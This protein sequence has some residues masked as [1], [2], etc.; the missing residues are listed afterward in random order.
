VIGWALLAV[1]LSAIGPPVDAE[2]AKRRPIG[3]IRTGQSTVSIPA[4][5]GAIGTA[6]A[7]CPTGTKAVSGGFSTSPVPNELS[8]IS[9]KRS[10]RR[11]W[12]AS[13]QQTTNNAALAELTTFVYCDRRLRRAPVASAPLSIPSGLPQTATASCPLGRRAISG[14]FEI[15]TDITFTGAGTVLA[16]R[17]SQP[18]EWS[19]TL[20]NING[21]STELTAYA[22]CTRRPGRL[23]ER[24]GAATLPDS[25]SPI[26]TATAITASC[27][28]R[29]GARSGGFSIAATG[30]GNNYSVFESRRAGR[31]WRFSVRNFGQPP[32]PL[33]A[34][35]YCS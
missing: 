6:T 20:Q 18:G 34:L 4:V 27:P 30:G 28:K 25:G 33:T 22:Y 23:R 11:A 21:P 35:A 29:I 2:G 14:G 24:E 32:T 16:S 15:A 19:V 10:G 7:T 3:K 13:V 8:V 12:T 26:T 5:Q 17:R 1:A 9:S 31:R